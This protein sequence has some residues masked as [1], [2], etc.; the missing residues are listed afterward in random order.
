TTEIF[1]ALP[2]V[3]AVG[4]PASAPYGMPTT[5]TARAVDPDGD[6][7]GQWRFEVAY[8]PAGMT[9]N[10]VTG[11]V[12]WT[13][14][15]PMFD[16]TL[17]VSWAITLD[18]PGAHP[19]T[20]TLR[21]EDPARRYPLLRT[22]IQIP[23][24]G[25]L[26]IGDFDGDHDTEMLL[27]GPRS[28]LEIEADG[29]GGYRESW[30]YPFALDP[31]DRPWAFSDAQTMTAG[32]V[33]GDGHYEIFVTAGKRIFKLD[34][35]ERRVVASVAVGA[36]E[37]CADLEYGDLD[38]DGAAELVCAAVN[39]FDPQH[40]IVYRASDLSVVSTLG[41]AQYGGTL[42]L[43][44]V[45][46][47]AALE[48]VTSGGY[49]IDG[50]TTAVQWQR[51]QGFDLVAVGN[52]DGAGAD[53]IVAFVDNKV[54]AFRSGVATPLFAVAS[55]RLD[56]L[57]V[58]DIGGDTRA[59]IL[60]GDNQSGNVTGYRYDA[61]TGT[62]GSVFQIGNQ[63][64]G[65]SAFG[66]GDVDGDSK[67]EIVWGTNLSSSGSD[68]LVVAGLNPG[69]TI[70]WTNADPVQLEGP[71]AGGALA[72]NPT[73]PAAP[74]FVTTTGESPQTSSRLVRLAP[75]GGLEIGAQLGTQVTSVFST[76][77][78][79]D[80]D[81]DGT[82]E[83][84]LANTGSFDATP[85]AY[86]FFAEHVEWTPA[87]FE[88]AVQLVSGNIYGD[89]RD[90]LVWLGDNGVVSVLDVATRQVLW[91]SE[92]LPGARGLLLTDR[93]DNGESE[94]IAF[95]PSS[96]H[97]FMRA[98]APSLFQL[99][100]SFP[101]AGTVADVAAGDTD[102]DGRGETFVLVNPPNVPGSPASPSLLAPFDS[103]LR[104][105][106]TIPLPWRALTIAIEPS[107]F[108]RKN[109]LVGRSEG[110]LPG[111][112]L[113]TIDPRNGAV[114]SESPPLIGAIARDS[115]H[116][117]DLGSGGTRLSIGTDAGMYLTR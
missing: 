61:G 51:P 41:P 58:G 4:A 101:F 99:Y 40:L 55:P 10:P 15:G 30:E 27:L 57:F 56:A 89:P 67:T 19:A 42:A 102:G 50:K 24:V 31:A 18:R 100:A 28:L 88:P 80:Y 69:I 82:D 21:V 35:V 109:L 94:I 54:T 3:T 23:V 53:E 92:P 20:G 17:D 78:V 13:P 95:T 117:V 116:Y 49:V 6:P 33:D 83:A 2:Y 96:V 108:A 97:V 26:R 1:D 74:L 77:A 76:L 45:D 38:R 90:E 16:R 43:G 114:V 34:G 5:F 47:D 113:V 66:V 91:R 39:G 84:L 105:S 87:Q 70:E 59:E 79:R 36:D 111:G 71:F 62:A 63:E 110:L 75:D 81:A 107:V 103:E 44:N 7:V 64:F 73:S 86:D 14:Q 37:Q 32:D 68:E 46:A 112:R 48:I 72:R 60:A 8:G 93:D 12:A 115:V 104:A 11:A 98:V 25:S 22:G 106:E 52:V 65:V 85:T 9:V 29:A